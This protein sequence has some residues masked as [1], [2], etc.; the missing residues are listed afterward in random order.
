MKFKSNIPYLTT[1][2]VLVF[3]FSLN[4]QNDEM[5]G[6]EI[7]SYNPFE[8]ATDYANFSECTPYNTAEKKAC[9]TEKLQQYF[10]ENLKIPK[11]TL[12]QNF[13][14]KV[15]F[16]F[17]TDTKGKLK[18]TEIFNRPESKFIEEKI[19]QVLKKLPS[20][21]T[22]Q[23]KDTTVSTGYVLYAKFSPGNNTRLRVI[24]I[25]V[26]KEKIKETEET[27][28]DYPF[29]VATDEAPIFPGCEDL[30]KNSRSNCFQ[31]KINKYI[32]KN[33][34]FPKEIQELN[35]S[36]G[37][38]YVSFVIEKDG[39]IKN[40]RTRGSHPLLELEGR[41][42]I[43]KLPP[44]IPGKLKGKAVSSSFIVPINVKFY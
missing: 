43:T 32:A 34:N 7:T 17:F 1:F 27:D 12:S 9:F 16:K 39:S 8:V 31:Q 14:G 10:N 26:N 24:D 4:A 33:Y 23:L 37:K 11:D 21:K 5:D 25:I 30:P 38:V 2:T 15:Y 42:I 36:G 6:Q 28:F 19:D 29:T 20:L 35:V 13:D 40:I 41:R 44:I 22:V 3:I 18:S